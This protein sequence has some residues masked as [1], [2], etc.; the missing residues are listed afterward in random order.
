MLMR[1][2]RRNL[3]K[4]ADRLVRNYYSGV[5]A[6]SENVWKSI[7]VAGAEDI[8][9][10]TNYNADHPEIPHGVSV[11]FTTTIRLPTQPNKVFEFLRSGDQRNQ[12]FF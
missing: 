7:P 12:V 1:D 9:V 2:G 10:T 6:S 8:L 5:S 11:T 3:L 4:L